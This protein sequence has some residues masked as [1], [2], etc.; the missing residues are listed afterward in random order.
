MTRANQLSPRRHKQISTESRFTA[1][2]EAS[3]AKVSVDLAAG[4][5]RGGD[6]EGDSLFYVAGV[7]GS[8]FA[9]RLVGDRRANQLLGGGGDDEISGGG[10]GDTLGGGRGDDRL[11][12]GE[13]SDVALYAGS[14]AA[15]A[16]I[17]SADG[18]SAWVRDR[19]PLDG[20]EGV[21]ALRDVEQLRFADGTVE[22]SALIAVGPLA[23]FAATSGGLGR[24]LWVTDGTAGGTRVLADVNPGTAD[25]LAD[26]ANSFV[27]LGDGRALFAAND[28]VHGWE[29]W[30]TDGTAGGTRLLADIAPGASDSGPA[31]SMRLADGRVLFTADDGVSG[32]EPWVTDG[33]AEGTRSVADI[34]PGSAGS[35]AD[36]FSPLGDGQALFRADDGMHGRELWVTDGTAAGTRLLADIDPATPSEQG[37]DVGHGYPI[38]FAILGDGAIFSADDGVHGRELWITDGTA[39]GTR[40]LAD[41]DPAALSGWE[42]R[43]HGMPSV[44]VVLDGGRALL[45]ARDSATGSE[46]WITDGTAVGTRLLKDIWSGPDHSYPA[47]FVDLGGG[48]VVFGAYSRNEW[49][50][51]GPDNRELWV[52]DGTA[53]GTRLLKDIRPGPE[54]SIP[55]GLVGLGDGRGLFTADDGTHGRA[56][57][58]TDGTEAGTMLVADINPGYEAYIFDLTPIGGG[59][60]LFSADD[61]VHG[62]EL[63]ITDGTAEGTR[64]VAELDGAPGKS[65]WPGG[66]APV[67]LGPFG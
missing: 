67:W 5:G 18:R 40:L 47:N 21:D 16:V 7:E 6:A 14:A 35:K 48:R 49:S 66:F 36:E 33:T 39:D 63:W 42:W 32:R 62:G 34:A 44:G 37:I 12:G 31:L 4:R 53:E 61:G 1:S 41:I 11:E 26:Y 27:V 22:P 3:P 17:T 45:E 2:Y 23:V 38:G 25:G 60:A 59:R 50:G 24:E 46:L 8:G 9:D 10:G 54:S 56:L 19:N 30:V 20:D 58:I 43:G 65:G 13:G 52:T 29:I 28:G 55:D 64:M 15:Y 51:Y 57:W